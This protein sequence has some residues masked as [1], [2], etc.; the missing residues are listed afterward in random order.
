[1]KNKTITKEDILTLWTAIT[2]LTL[3]ASEIA[4]TIHYIITLFS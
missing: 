4:N 3:S 1:M 2:V